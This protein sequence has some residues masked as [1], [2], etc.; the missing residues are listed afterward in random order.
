MKKALLIILSLCSVLGLTA[1][2]QGI[3]RTL[4][5]PGKPSEPLSGV[6]IHVLEYSNAIVSKKGGRFSFSLKD[7]KQGDS[8]TISRIQKKGYSLVDKQVKGR[9]YAYSNSV[10]IEIVMV[11]D[12]Q[13]EADKKRIEDK[14]YDKAKKNYDQ[15][16]LSLE[17]QLKQKAISEREYRLKYEQLNN[18]YNN[19]VQMIDQMAERY[20]TTDYKGLSD[21]SR[22]TLE[23]I[24]NADLERADSL[25][26]SKGNFDN[27]EL[28][29][30][31]KQE[32]VEKTEK[33]SQQLKDDYNAE[34]QDLIQD[35]FNKY[36]IHAA[37]YRNDSAAYYLERVV[38]LD[39][40]T[41]KLLFYTGAFFD[42]YLANEIKAHQYYMR[43]YKYGKTQYGEYSKSFGNICTAIGR[44]YDEL[45]Q[46]DS[47]M[48]WHHKALDIY[49]RAEDADSLDISMSYTLI[50]R[51]YVIN[52]QYDK[53]LEYTLK[54]LEIRERMPNADF[55][56]LGQSYNNLGYLSEEAGNF[57]Q[58]LEYHNKAL[59][60]R[61]KEYGPDDPTTAVSYSQIGSTYSR[62]GNHEKA[63]DYYN[64][65]LAIYQHVF[66]PS[67]PSTISNQVNIGN[68]YYRLEDYE[69]AVEHYQEALT[70][71]EKY[72]GDKYS[73]T[74]KDAITTYL[75]WIA[76][77]YTKMGDNDHSQQYLQ[78]IYEIL[79]H[80]YG[81]D[82][83][84]LAEKY[85]GLGNSFRTAGFHDKA[86]EFFQKAI[87]IFKATGAEN[88]FTA[89]ANSYSGHIYYAQEQYEKAL[90]FYQK[91]V[92]TEK[93]V[94][95]EQHPY[96][97]LCLNYVGNALKQL[98]KK[99]KALEYYQLALD[100]LEQPTYNKEY[101]NYI[102]NI[103]TAIQE[104]KGAN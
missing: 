16:V 56:S 85:V 23:C 65:S 52:Q 39:S 14:A 46:Q 47:A 24:E 15:K 103:K 12:Q 27:R 17:N 94:L 36:T 104:L 30:A 99:D 90:E 91:A 101:N 76:I 28:E 19:Y 31:N 51:A 66:G 33:L 11:S 18:D 8:Y 40:T 98:N 1:Q 75:A 32:L 55:G 97:A 35:Y 29:L 58:A 92:E 4:E 88:E 3:V 71:S 5:R 60:Y 49:S 45:H 20:A 9:R 102:E 84:Q 78:R 41:A 42:T 37:N 64:K 63:I 87:N 80:R 72:Y 68:I 70:G 25:I 43:A 48:A 26:S 34:L 44:I 21:I 93:R 54:G 38:R 67:H 2:Q 83:I 57:I 73:D 22:K 10:P 50:G 53:A 86:L 96:T 74:E 82:S 7:K 89:S 69:N 61:L 81:T 6:T 59:E 95:G 62:L 13:L 77:C 100:I 79:E